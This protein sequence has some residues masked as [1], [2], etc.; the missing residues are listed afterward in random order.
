MSTNTILLECNRMNS[1]DATSDNHSLWTNNVSEGLQLNPGDRVSVE[2][3]FINEIGSGAQT[4]EFSDDQ[5]ET[6]VK[7]NELTITMEYYK[8]ADAE[9]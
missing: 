7:E 5:I 8:N 2:A 4:I 1:E 6:N 9:C 3:A